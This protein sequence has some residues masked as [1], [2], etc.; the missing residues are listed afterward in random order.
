MMMS[1]W[2][3]VFFLMISA[4]CNSRTAKEYF[5]RPDYNECITL[6]QPNMMACAGELVEIPAGL[7]VPRDI[8]SY[9][10]IKEYGEAREYGHYICLRFP[11]RCVKN[12]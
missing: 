5:N 9:Q 12:P 4:S 2:H 11:N 3:L 6:E 1:V 7:I 8:D 10:A